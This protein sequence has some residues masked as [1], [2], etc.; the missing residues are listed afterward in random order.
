[1]NHLIDWYSKGF[2]L[3]TY[4]LLMW[5]YSRNHPNWSKLFQLGLVMG[6]TVYAISFSFLHMA[7]SAKLIILFKDLIIL[8]SLSAFFHTI[9][10]YKKVYWLAMILLYGFSKLFIGH[11]QKSTVYGNMIG[12]GASDAKE[13]ELLVQIDEHEGKK[14]I[15]SVLEKY[16]LIAEPSFVLKDGGETDLDDYYSIEVPDDQEKNIT[17]IKSDLSFCAHVIWLEDNE[18]LKVD[19]KEDDPVGDIQKS[20][21]KSLTNDPLN[22]QQWAIETLGWNRVI[23]LFN[24]GAFQPKKRAKIFILDSGVDGKHE[25]LKDNYA[26]FNKSDD[27]D[28]LGHGTHVAGIADAVTNN[29][30][31][32]SS[33]TPGKEFASITSIKVLGRFGAGTQR[34]IINAILKAADAGADVINM[35]LGGKSM[36]SRQKAYNEAVAYANKKGCI[37]VVA[38]G[39]DNADARDYAPANAIGVITVSAIDAELNKAPFSN[40]VNDIKYKLAAPGM[41]ILSATP[42]NQYAVYNGTSM[43]APFVTGLVAMLKSL[44][45]EL[46]TAEVYDILSSTGISSKSNPQTGPVIQAD[47]ALEYVSGNK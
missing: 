15:Q 13:W 19:P 40:Y 7:A 8:G 11:W 24:N 12:A 30:V 17:E 14:D 29:Q 5:H 27:V 22:H 23:Q 25:D 44:K 36:D 20:P 37:V 39:N 18:M 38:A 33:V 1:M 47:K 9:R 2:W 46:T 45:P 32:I 16:H 35:S 3:A 6:S 26:S 21:F 42:G 31:G 10:D 4:S 28:E 43:A 34:D 41:N